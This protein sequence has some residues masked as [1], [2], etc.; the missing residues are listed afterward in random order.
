[1]HI[2]AIDQGTSGAKALVVDSDVGVVAVAD[3]P[4]HPTYLSDR[5]VELN[6]QELL[7]SVLE[8]GRRAVELAGRQIDVVSLANQGETVLA[9]DPATGEPIT[10]ALVW[11]DRRSQHICDELAAERDWVAQRT[12][13]VLDPYFSAPKM[14]WL[15]R[16]LTRQG[17][18]T[19]T[20]CW[21][22]H[23]LT[24]AFVTDVSTASRSLLIDLDSRQWDGQLLSLFGLD[25]DARPRIVN[26]DEVVG[27]TEAFGGAAPV[28]GLVVDQQAALLAQ[29]C[30]SVA[31][32]KCTF[33]TGAFLLANTGADAVRSGAGLTSSVA[34][35]TSDGVAYCIDGQVYAAASAIRWAASVGLIADA[36]EL[37][38]AAADD[39][40]GVLCVPALA[41]LA[42]PWWRAE[43]TASLSGLTLSTGRGQIVRALLEGVAAQL[44]ELTSAI[45][46]DTGRPLTRLK[47]DGG[48]TN[49]RALMQAVADVLQLPI[50]VHP[51]V[52]ATALGSAALAHKALEP[53]TSLREGIFESAP[54]NSYEP[55][56]SS[57]RAATFRELWRAQVPALPPT[58]GGPR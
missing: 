11:Q 26:C 16:H 36:R 49:S 21:L 52:H 51:A 35:A 10:P 9:W 42:A 48:L 50:D 18:V 44:A 41:G 25:Q 53:A 30:L 12:G 2:L 4:L 57:D 7:R 8:A 3:Y 56:W 33:G 22:V 31:D 43:A 6:P 27:H 39:A 40:G 34:W 1:M 19:T 32:A 37:D 14:A 54:A 29:G 46:S 45:D 55:R 15:R 24:G 47:V 23:Q 20:D 58:A 38:A 17:V 28:A 13:L 5:G